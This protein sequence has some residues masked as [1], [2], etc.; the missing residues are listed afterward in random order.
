MDIFMANFPYMN[1][2][3]QFLLNLRDEAIISL[4]T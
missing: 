4:Q 2:K 3:P 1:E